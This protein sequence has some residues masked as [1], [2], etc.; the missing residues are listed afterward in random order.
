MTDSRGED[1]VPFAPRM[2]ELSLPSS[3]PYRAR[4]PATRVTGVTVTPVLSPD[5]SALV[6][7]LLS[8]AR[9]QIDIEQASIRNS[10]RYEL[11]PLLSAAV[12]ASRDGVSVRILLDGSRYN[13]EGPADNDEM[14]DLVNALAGAGNLTL[15]ARILKPAAGGPEAVHTKGVIVDG[16]IVLISSINWNAN[17]PNFNRE[18]GVILESPALG[19]YFASVFEEDWRRAGAGAAPPGP[20][21]VKIA[22]AAGVVLVLFLVYL[23]RRR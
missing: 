4:F 2:V 7:Q 6:L 5:T 3:V 20:D 23:R 13:D 16:R 8:G 18:A 22:A 9:E 21:R 1:I 19:S 15:A 12:N 11:D 10:S 14:A 17:S